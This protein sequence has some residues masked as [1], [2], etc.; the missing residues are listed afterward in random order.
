MRTR[1]SSMCR[2]CAK[3]AHVLSTATVRARARGCAPY[4]KHEPNFSH[5]PRVPVGK[6]LVKGC[7]SLEHS[8]AQHNAMRVRH[9]PHARGLTEPTSAMSTSTPYHRLH[10]IWLYLSPG[11]CMKA[12]PSKQHGA[13]IRDAARTR[14]KYRGYDKTHTI[15]HC[16]R[17]S[18]QSHSVCSIWK[19]LD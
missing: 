13:T 5:A 16:A 9:P 4:T 12:G 1:S 3:Q 7:G 17:T 8:T 10:V 6:V 19:G 18:Y 11:L 14:T 15:T 2:C